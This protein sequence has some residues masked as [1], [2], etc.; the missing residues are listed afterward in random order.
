M[1]L[2]SGSSGNCYYLGNGDEGILID[3]GLSIR[4]VRK[5]LKEVG[6]ILERQIRGVILTHDHADHI[7]AIGAFGGSARLPIY[8][9]PSVFK[10]IDRSRYVTEYIEISERNYIA[11]EEPFQLAG[12]NITPFSVP[13]DASENVGYYIEA[14][15]F[16]FAI[17]TDVGHVTPKIKH[18]L[19]RAEHLVVEANYDRE[20]LIAGP[21]PDFL[22]ERVSGSLGHLSNQETGELLAEIFHSGMQMIWL[23]H[24]S[25]DNNHPEL[26]WKT[27]ED[28]LFREGIRVGKDVSLIALK[29]TSPSPLY[30]L[31]N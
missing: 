13:H 11:S 20:M 21:Y 28:R 9:T 30:T 6:I 14:E 8:A 12:F 23:C 2:G 29:R 17:A 18:Y 1:S 22:K 31:K 7:R 4:L 5:A 15:D 16:S 25:K 10:G 26:C 24:L 3:A 19:Q 27:I